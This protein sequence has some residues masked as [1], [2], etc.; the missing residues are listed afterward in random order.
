MKNI[1]IIIILIFGLKSFSS[2]CKGSYAV[3]GITVSYPNLLN[4]E[5]LKAIRTDKSNFSAIIDTINLGELNSTNNYSTLLEFD[6]E[7]A[8]YIL[9]VENTSYV[10][11]ISEIVIE[12]KGCKEKI[13][14]FNYNF[15]GKLY[16]DKKLMIK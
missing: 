12:R 5:N 8:N 7:S 3:A 6:N 15:N 9:F 14:K 10:D 13:K 1:G 16:T 11:T 4:A 2:C